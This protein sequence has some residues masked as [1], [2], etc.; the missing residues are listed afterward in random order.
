MNTRTYSLTIPA[1]KSRVFAYLANIENLPQWATCFC[2]QLETVG[3]Q[4]WVTTPTGKVLCEIRA[5]AGTGTIDFLAGPSADQM[6]RWPA[7]VLDLPDGESL[8]LFTSIQT[9]EVSDE[10]FDAQAADVQ[11]EF[12]NLLRV[13]APVH[14]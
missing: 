12:E 1:P 3:G 5:H 14:A 11:V 13:L 7:R 10:E 4:H 8:Y 2:Q 9:P 6:G